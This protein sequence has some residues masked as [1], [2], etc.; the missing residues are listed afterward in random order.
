MRRSYWILAN[1]FILGTVA[2]LCARVAN[3]VVAAEIAAL[4]TSPAVVAVAAPAAEGRS[5]PGTRGD[6]IAD[7]NLFNADPPGPEPEKPPEGPVTLG[8][9]PPRGPPPAPEDECPEADGAAMLM[10]TMV[11]DPASRSRAIV[12]EGPSRQTQRLVQAGQTIE[13][14]KIVAIQRERV[15]VER[16]DGYACLVLGERPKRRPPVARRGPAR[17]HRAAPR[18]SFKDSIQNLGG[19]RYAVDRGFIEEQLED[20]AKLSQGVRLTPHREGGRAAGFKMAVVRS[21]SVYHHLG[22][23]RGDILTAA[24]GESVTTPNQALALLDKLKTQRRVT[25]DVKRRGRPLT[26][27]YEIR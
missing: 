11:A 3:N 13:P 22:L 2:W 21:D 27:E 23:R 8:P 24:N 17:T 5:P 25:I 20:L 14:G 10:A 7:R 16:D 26:L 18:K 15:V 4:P 6:A 12:G 1:L 9:E 19:N